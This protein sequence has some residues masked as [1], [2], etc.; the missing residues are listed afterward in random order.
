MS[1]KNQPPQS[2]RTVCSTF[3]DPWF[4]FDKHQVGNVYWWAREKAQFFALQS[5]GLEFYS[6][7]PQETQQGMVTKYNLRACEVAICRLTDKPF[8]LPVWG[9]PGQ[10]GGLSQKEGREPLWESTWGFPL[11]STFMCTHVHSSLHT[12]VTCTG[13]LL[14]THTYNKE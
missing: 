12:H 4:L 14:N 9:V 3:F 8:S 11:N 5:W 2:S 13:I 7:N 1:W 6:Q 10:S